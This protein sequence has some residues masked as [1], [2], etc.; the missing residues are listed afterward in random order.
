MGG[1]EPSVDSAKQQKTVL[2]TGCSSGI[3]LD[4]AHVLAQRGWRV[5]ATCRHQRD[6]DARLAEGLD[7][8]RLD[9]SDESSV[10]RAV[11]HALSLGPVHALVNN[12]AFALPGAVEDLPRGGLRDIFETNL[13]GTHDL[14]Q[15]L[16]PHFRQIGEGRIVNISSV[17]GLVG[18]PWRGAYVATKFALEGLTDVLRIEMADTPVHVILVEPGP[19]G[20]KI[21]Q[22]SIPHF[23]RWI[24][25]KNSPRIEQYRQTLLKRLYEP[26]AKKD[27]WELPSRAVSDKIVHAL[28]AARPQP[29]YYV[30]RPTR[31]AGLGRRILSTRALDWFAQRS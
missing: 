15:R 24:D 16:I 27:K 4:A 21:R 5:L 11:G 10:A 31:I 20:T 9:L 8:F 12:G 13:F 19:I 3:G 22:N 17:L 6:V 28:E 1:Q 7:S 2:V 23:E 18:I 14:T 30:T 29:R 25:W 26:E